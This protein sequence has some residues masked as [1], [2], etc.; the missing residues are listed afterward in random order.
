MNGTLTPMTHRAT[1]LVQELWNLP[2]PP[3]LRR[4]SCN[5]VRDDGLSNGDYVEQLTS[6]LCLTLAEEQ[7]RPQQ[8]VLQKAFEGKLVRH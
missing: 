8:A 6:L 5:I 7:S 4:T 2:L 3:R 1:S